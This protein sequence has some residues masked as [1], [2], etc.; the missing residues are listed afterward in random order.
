MNMNKKLGFGVMR[1]P[2]LGEEVDIE[3]TIEMVDY[4]IANGFTYFDTAHGY[5]QGKSE[6]AIKASLSSRYPREAYVLTTKL[7]ENFFKTEEEIRPL[8]Q[9]QLENCGVEYFDCYL[10]H[11]QNQKNF[12]H[13]QKYKAY[14]TAFSLK[15]EGKIKHVGLSFH[16]TADVLDTILQKYPQIEVVQLQLNYVDYEDASVQGR[17][18]YEVCLKHQKPVIV[19]EPVKG[20]NLA[21][22]PPV[23][24]EI[25]DGLGTAT[26]ASYAMRYAA[27][28]SNVIMVLS[29]MSNMD[30]MQDNVATMK[31]FKALTVEEKRAIERVRKTLANIRTIA[32]TNCKY[33]IPV[34]PKKIKIPDLFSLMNTKQLYNDWNADF[35]Y[36]TVH[37]EKGN[38][39]SDCIKCAKCEQ[40]CPQ[41]LAI[42]DLL[43]DVSNTFE[44]AQ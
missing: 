1:L 42:R 29:G 15:A 26:P 10:M 33:C 24:Q 34:C 37:S 27:D 25:F 22:L 4:F 30:Q 13:F 28:F 44:K 11:A 7:T 41:H 35:Y 18:C 36:K 17:A 40:V 9:K 2:M 16:D 12:Q 8:F 23:A 20:G 31:N 32:C 43:V 39:A 3:K 19:M 6:P 21:V 38:K 5:I 14:E